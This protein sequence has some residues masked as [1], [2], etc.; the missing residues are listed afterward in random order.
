MLATLKKADAEAETE[1]VCRRQRD[2]PDDLLSLA[3]KVRM[4]GGER[5]AATEVTRGRVPKAQANARGAEVRHAG[6]KGGARN[7]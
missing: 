2:Y 7:K 6:P 5:G 3:S 4:V 1:N